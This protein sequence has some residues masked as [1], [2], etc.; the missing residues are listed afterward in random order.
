MDGIEKIHL[1]TTAESVSLRISPEWYSSRL[2][3][4]DILYDGMFFILDS[5]K[6]N[7]DRLGK[8]GTVG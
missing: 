7:E 1:Q 8:Y 3:I 5:S 6:L 2:E 4:L